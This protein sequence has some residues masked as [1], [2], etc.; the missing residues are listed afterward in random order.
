MSSRPTAALLQ[1]R[2]LHFAHPASPP[3]FTDLSLDLSPGLVRLDGEPGSGQ[4]TLLRLLA[5]DLAG[6]GQFTLGGQ[7]LAP[8][9]VDGRR[10]V[11]WMDPRDVR[12]DALTPAGLMAAWQAVHPQLDEAACARHWD[13]FSLGPHLAKPLSMLSTGS[14]R[15]AALA[16]ALSAGCAVTLLDEPTA[17]LDRPSVAWL[18]QA[19]TELSQAHPSRTWLLAA[20]YGLEDA[21]PWA[22]TVTL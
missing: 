10:Q 20:A 4:T 6:R 1:V 9:S 15:K 16:V 7:P 8:G 13:G 5:G 3:L 18:A 12:W 22:A 21:L 11:H 17:G 14:R 19:L 2:H